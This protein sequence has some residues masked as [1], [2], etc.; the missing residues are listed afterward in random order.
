MFA[1]GIR[2]VFFSFIMCKKNNELIRIDSLE[3]GACNMQRFRT[4][5]VVVVVV[6]LTEFSIT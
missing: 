5:I 2:V 6:A 3:T 4:T 1:R